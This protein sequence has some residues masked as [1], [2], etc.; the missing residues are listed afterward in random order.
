MWVEQY[1]MAHNKKLSS[2]DL[3][4]RGEN[5]DVSENERSPERPRKILNCYRCRGEGHCA[6][7]CLSK[8]LNGCCPSGNQRNTCYRCGGLGLESR[9]FRSV[10]RSQPSQRSGPSGAKPPVQVHQVGCAVK[11]PEAPPQ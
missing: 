2:K 3:I 9:D 5:L 1:L 7:D 11:L 10:L 6:V 4:R 8:V